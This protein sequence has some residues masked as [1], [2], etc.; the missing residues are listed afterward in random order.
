M[1]AVIHES[2]ARA[3]S[4]STA[5]RK[6]R[7]QQPLHACVRT[8]LELFFRD[9]DGHEVDGVYDMV[10]GQVEHAMLESVMNY[11]RGN[12]TRAS[13]VLGINRSTL[14]KKLKQYNLL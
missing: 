5:A 1:S 2:E 12:Q 8:S 3:R 4:G 14:R 6:E 9:M 11:T 13:E 10:L 7:R